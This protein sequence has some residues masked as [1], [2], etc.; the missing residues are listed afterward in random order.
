MPQKHFKFFLLVFLLY[1]AKY[2]A[3]RRILPSECLTNSSLFALPIARSYC[4]V[5][6]TYYCY[7]NLTVLPL[8]GSLSSPIQP[9][10]YQW[11]T[12]LFN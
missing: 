3:Y 6:I 2:Q 12:L 5:I 7:N 9:P 11:I 1:I 10:R 4:K 8:V